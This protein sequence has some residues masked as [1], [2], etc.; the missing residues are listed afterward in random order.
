L[1]NRNRAQGTLAQMHTGPTLQQL[2]AWRDGIAEEL[3]FWRHWLDTCGIQWSDDYAK[4]FNPQKP[5]DSTLQDVIG[6]AQL[7]SASIL[8]IGA[9]PVTV[10]GYQMPG[11]PIR[12]TAVDPLA[13]GYQRL[14]A[15][16]NRIPVI[17]TEF[18]LAEFAASLFT[19]QQFDI[20][21]CRNALDH[22]FDPMTGILE[23]LQV[24]KT[25]G[26]VLLRHSP[27]EAENCCYEGLHQ[28]NFDL[29]RGRLVLWNKTYK[30][31]VAD[32][33]PWKVDMNCSVQDDMIVCRIQRLDDIP[34]LHSDW[35]AR[36]RV[37]QL[38]A[39]F[40]HLFVEDAFERVRSSTDIAAL[41][42][43]S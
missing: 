33:I 31:D 30:V 38:F 13:H 2:H 22:S 12:I 25:G 27:N 9:G 4:R 3:Q 43:S 36:A 40:V 32:S 35:P 5:L 20:V 19:S 42:G 14:L 41:G 10:L 39:N 7:D 21:H 6:E 1:T 17:K 18:A 37:A 34:A 26:T 29:I 23:M 28:F 11:V 16:R 8:D 15:D 24:V